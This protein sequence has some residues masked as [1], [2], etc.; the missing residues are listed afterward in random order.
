MF[1]RL[2]LLGDVHA[3]DERLAAAFDIFEA[4]K[5]DQIL[6]VGDVADGRG[7]LARC[8]A[9]LHERN[10]LTVAGNHER[11][12]LRDTVRTLP[13]A[14]VRHAL[15]ASTLTYLEELPKT[16]E[17]PTP[18]GMLLLCHGVG[19]NDMQQLRADD[20]GYGLHCNHDLAHLLR[21]NKYALVVGGHTHQRMVRRF[22][23]KELGL[24]GGASLIFVNPGTLTR[25]DSPC[26]AVLDLDAGCVRFF[27]LEDPAA[28][29]PSETLPLP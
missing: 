23:G 29:V 6:C 16:R 11:W 1:R 13:H 3:E 25:T 12:L 2:G 18:L 17:V 21:D 26:C 27:A 20:E 4:E 19:T 5:V 28:P 10:A 14:H 22:H 24:P 9:L 15:D 8:C 7:D